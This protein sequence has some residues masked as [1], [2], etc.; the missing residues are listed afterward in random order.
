[1]HRIN[2]DVQKIYGKACG[3]RRLMLCFWPSMIER[4]SSGNGAM[5]RQDLGAK[6]HNL[7]PVRQTGLADLKKSKPHFFKNL[8][9]YPMQQA[10]FFSL[11]ALR[12]VLCHFMPEMVLDLHGHFHQQN[13][14]S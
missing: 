10:F 1:M 14:S 2:S 9:Q 7:L 4:S 12:K 13:F 11:V 3:K 5:K 8:L 6:P